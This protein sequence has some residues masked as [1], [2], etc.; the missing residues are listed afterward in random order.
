MKVLYL[1]FYYEPDLC[2]GSF[3]NT[4]ISIKLSQKH[5]VD[6]ITTLPN[7]YGSYQV[8]AQEDEKNTENLTIKRIKVF[9]HQSG[10]LGQVISFISFFFVTLRT[11][12][13]KKY[14][15]VVASSSRLFTA[16]LGAYIAKKKKIPYYL[17][18]RDL[19][20]ETIL[21]ITKNKLVK[22]IFNYILV[23]I[24]KFTFKSAIHINLVSEGFKPYFV[25]YQRPNFTF[26]P[27]G[28]DDEFLN[29]QASKVNNSKK[30]LI[31]YAGNIG[32]GQGLE[33]IIPYF[34]QKL[35]ENG[36]I[37]VIG[38]GGTKNKLVSEI[39]KFGID[40][41][42]ILNPV[43]RKLLMKYYEEADF[44]FLHLNDYP[45]FKR[46]LPSKLFE[47]GA[48]DKPIIAGVSGYAKEFVEN[49]LENIILFEPGNIKQLINLYNDYE[50]K[51]YRRSTFIEKFRR[52]TIVDE[53]VFSIENYLK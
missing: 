41:V 4:P 50:M 14:D 1:T 5:E 12:K 10:I 42:E 29:V 25:K 40:N 51:Y 49:Y 24:E 32:E 46:V 45:A 52:D 3:R 36:K 16:F 37:Q 6:V 39:S 47:Y 15:L 21:D 22:H 31:V 38:D 35:G 33:K 19:F 7:R 48:Y 8:N 30:K 27:N 34:A 28:I 44:L 43:N 11:V 18:I 9:N 53:I 23:R 26:F 20:R 2:A 17:D 13:N